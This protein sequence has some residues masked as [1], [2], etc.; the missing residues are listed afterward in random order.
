MSALISIIVPCFNQ[1]QYLGEALQSVYDQTFLNWECLIVND[2]STDNTPEIAKKWVEKDKRFNYIFQENGGLSSA[3][4]L[5][6]FHSKGIFIL[7][8]DADDL[9]S[10]EYLSLAVTEFNEDPSL[11]IVY[12]KAE[13]FGEEVGSLELKPFTI[14]GMAKE[15]MIFCT[16]MFRKTEWEKV[17]GYDPKMIYG[18]EDWEFWIS[19]LKNGGNVKRLEEVGFFYRIRMNSMLRTMN[20]ENQKEMLEYLSVKHADFFVNQLGSF[21]ELRSQVVEV[22]K[23]YKL[24]LESEKFAID[25]FLKTFFGFTLFGKY[26]R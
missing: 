5:G 9:I 11:K 20:N 7:P 26:K 12:C 25:L 17:G 24:K 15:N 19:I 1:S 2:G 16:A 14:K 23:H 10:S 13:K 8:L 4:N 18:L 22:E 3:R 6:V 21:F